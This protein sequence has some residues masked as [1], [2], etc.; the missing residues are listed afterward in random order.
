MLDKTRRSLTAK[1]QADLNIKNMQRLAKS[2]KETIIAFLKKAKN[3]DENGG[4]YK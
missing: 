4:V 1:E 3:L 2:D